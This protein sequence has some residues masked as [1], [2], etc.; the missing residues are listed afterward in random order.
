MVQMNNIVESVTL[1]KEVAQSFQINHYFTEGIYVRESII[2]S[3][4]FVIGKKHK[5]SCM[6]ILSKG[7]MFLID[8]HTGDRAFIKAPFTF[9]SE[10]GVQKAALTLEECVFSNI[11]NNIDNERDI[12]ILEN[13]YVEEDN[14]D[15]LLYGSRGSSRDG[16]LN[17]GGQSSS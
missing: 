5:H 6:N 13:R 10:A 8:I 17:N 14:I 4:M 1:S 7:S 16:I 12:N 3:D 9:I 2:P 11:H 15:E